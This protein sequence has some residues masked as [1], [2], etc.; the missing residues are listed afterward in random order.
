MG[1]WSKIIA[2][3]NQIK[4]KQQTQQNKENKNVWY[5]I[6]EPIEKGDLDPGE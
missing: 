4:V 6:E 2:K 3:R 1:V 5:A